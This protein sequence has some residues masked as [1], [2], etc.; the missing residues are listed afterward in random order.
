MVA[1]TPIGIYPSGKTE[2][3]KRNGAILVLWDLFTDL[4]DRCNQLNLTLAGLDTHDCQ[5]NLVYGEVAPCL[6]IF[7]ARPR[8]ASVGPS[9]FRVKILREVMVMV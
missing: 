7:P 1:I 4:K 2:L 6:S 8:K 5:I 3:S 9:S